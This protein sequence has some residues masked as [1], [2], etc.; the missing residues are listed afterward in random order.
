MRAIL[1]QSE[2]MQS[3]ESGIQIKEL[4]HD[5]L[6]TSQADSEDVFQSLESDKDE[7][8]VSES[9]KVRLETDDDP[10]YLLKRL[11]NLESDN[12]KLNA[13]LNMIV[14]R[15]EAAEAKMVELMNDKSRLER[16]LIAARGKKSLKSQSRSSESRDKEMNTS[17][18]V[19]SD[20][21]SNQNAVISAEQRLKLPAGY[22][23]FLM[24]LDKKP[25]GSI[26]KSLRLGR[27]TA[28]SCNPGDRVLVFWNE[29]HGNYMV[30]QESLTLYFVN[31]DC[32]FTIEMALEDSQ[33]YPKTLLVE[34]IDKEY[35]HARKVRIL[36]PNKSIIKLFRKKSHC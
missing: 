29:L 26:A 7:V 32:V 2:N 18:A 30:Y 33:V 36:L 35:C 14:E 31:S 21:S 9:K 20:Q 16:E 23:H 27:I 11:E 25:N 13:E 4:G 22:C 24:H 3:M 34:V 19:V 28:T 15:K 12:K 8:E 17:V 5:R 10:T 1:E 6:D